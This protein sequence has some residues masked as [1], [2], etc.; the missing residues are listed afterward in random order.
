MFKCKHES[1]YKIVLE[2]NLKPFI[3]TVLEIVVQLL[4]LNSYWFHMMTSVVESNQQ[5]GVEVEHIPGGC[6]S[7]CQPVHVGI[8]KALKTFVCK[9]WEDWMLESGNNVSVVKP[10]T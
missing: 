10:P 6:I 7:L 8:N 1:C 9:D 5:L 4:L 3:E 2:N